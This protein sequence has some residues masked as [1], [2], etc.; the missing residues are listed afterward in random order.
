M[1]YKVQE[2]GNDWVVIDTW[3]HDP[4]KKLAALTFSMARCHNPDAAERIARALNYYDQNN[5]P[6]SETP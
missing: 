3:Y 2:D 4:V 5:F 1:R 6:E